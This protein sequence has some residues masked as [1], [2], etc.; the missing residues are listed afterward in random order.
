[1]TLAQR[2]ELTERPGYVPAVF[3]VTAFAAGV[4]IA[5]LVQALGGG[6]YPPAGKGTLFA[7]SLAVLG[8]SAILHVPIAKLDLSWLTDRLSDL[9]ERRSVV[10]APADR[11]PAVHAA[12][13]SSSE[14]TNGGTPPRLSARVHSPLAA[15]PVVAPDEV[16]PITI[17]AEPESLAKD[18]EITLEIHAP[19]GT[20]TVER[21]MEGTRIVEG[22][23]FEQA[24]AFQVR[25][26]LAHPKADNAAKTL[27]GRVASYREEVGRLFEALKETLATAQLDVGP[28]STPREVVAELRRVDAADPSRL[29]DLAVELEVSLY[30]DQEID[31]ATY[32]TVH[33]AID[34]LSLER[35]EE[36]T[37]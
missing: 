6:G 36:V 5:L 20:R 32:E 24:G 33:T 28:Q 2:L 17:E 15:G 11:E 12:P 26:T 16:I 3:T 4:Q 19:S 7:V 13:A 21:R 30:G 8:A 14:Q 22:I 27:E 1:M 23:S 18:L 10:L 29:A 34:A 25:V 37:G 31:R 35:P 9:N